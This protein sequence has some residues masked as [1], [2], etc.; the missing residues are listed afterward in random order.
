MFLVEGT[1]YFVEKEEAR[2]IFII[3]KLKKSGTYPISPMLFLSLIS[4]INYI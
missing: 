4:E 2:V 3:R 1:Q